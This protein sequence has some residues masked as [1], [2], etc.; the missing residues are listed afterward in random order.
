MPCNNRTFTLWRLHVHFLLINVTN[1]WSNLNGKRKNYALL[2]CYWYFCQHMFFSGTHARVEQSTDKV[3]TAAPYQWPNSCSK[4]SWLGGGG[5]R[6]SF[7]NLNGFLLCRQT[8]CGFRGLKSQTGLQFYHSVSIL[9]G[10]SFRNGYIEEG[11]NL[12]DACSEQST[13]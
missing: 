2:M 12:G 9:N 3:G 13:S 1:R 7:F 5:E 8:G 4:A 6:H 10:V 11:M